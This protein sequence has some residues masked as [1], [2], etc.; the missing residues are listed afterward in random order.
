MM[1]CTL[2]AQQLFAAE[3]KT[4]LLKIPPKK[5][6]EV[7]ADV[8]VFTHLFHATDEHFRSLLFIYPPFQLMFPSF[9]RQSRVTNRRKLKVCGE[10]FKVVLSL[11]RSLFTSV[12]MFPDL[13]A[14]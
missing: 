11:S 2:I 14:A 12:V 9:C 4:P 13:P 6:P 1:D 10:V 5:L 3:K 7:S 8:T